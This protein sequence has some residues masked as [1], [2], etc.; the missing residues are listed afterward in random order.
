[1]AASGDRACDPRLGRR[2]SRGRACGIPRMCVPTI[3]GHH[4]GL[5]RRVRGILRVCTV[6]GQCSH[7]NSSTVETIDVEDG[8]MRSVGRRG[9]WMH[10]EHGHQRHRESLRRITYPS[11]SSCQVMEIWMGRM[12][13]RFRPLTPQTHDDRKRPGFTYLGREAI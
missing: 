9:S 7:T 1:M 3:V 2:P 6:L 11:Q 4:C 5:L 12:W 8:S 13:T 10:D